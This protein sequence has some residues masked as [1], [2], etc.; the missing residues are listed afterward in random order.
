VRQRP[1]LGARE[2]ATLGHTVGMMPPTYVKPYAKH[3][4]TDAADAEPI[5]EA[6]SRPTMRLVPI[7]TVE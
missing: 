5:C 2:I 3:N 1:F 7:N 6:V 4:K